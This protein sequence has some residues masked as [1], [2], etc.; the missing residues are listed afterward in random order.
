MHF[1]AI[2][3]KTEHFLTK[4]HKKELFLSTFLMP[5][6]EIVRSGQIHLNYAASFWGVLYNDIDDLKDKIMV[7]Q[8]V[9]RPMLCTECLRRQVGNTFEII[10]PVFAENRIGWYNWC[11]VAGRT[12]TYMHWDSEEGTPA[13]KIWQHDIFHPDGKLYDANEIDLIRNFKF[14]TNKMPMPFSLS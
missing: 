7:C 5:P 13:P 9:K 14:D 3:C 6:A 8:K 2:L 4:T 12:Q 1:G 10:L 11:L